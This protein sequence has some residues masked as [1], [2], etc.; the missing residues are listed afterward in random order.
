MDLYLIAI[1]NVMYTHSL[2]IK[3]TTWVESTIPIGIIMYK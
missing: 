3:K 1:T 2:A